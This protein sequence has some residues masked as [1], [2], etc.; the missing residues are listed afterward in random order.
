M[1]HEH[2]QIVDDVIG[3]LSEAINVNLVALRQS[4]RS[5]VAH[6]VADR[7]RER[8]DTVVTVCGVPELSERPLVALA[9]AGVEVPAGAAAASIAAA[10]AA[11]STQLA[12]AR[13]VLVVDD[14]DDLDSA[15]AGAIV[16]ARARRAFPV[17]TVTRPSGLRR[18]TGR[19]LT[20]GIQPSVTVRLEP[21]DF[22]RLHQMVHR[23]LA[24]AIE[25]STTAR[26]ATVSGGLPGLVVAIVETARRSGLLVESDGIWR[27]DGDLWNDQLVQ[28]VDP[29]LVDL[30]DD[31]LDALTKLSFAGTLTVAQAREIVP[32]QL[33]AQ[34]DGL[35]LLQVAE[36]STGPL[37]GVFPPLVAEY[38]RHAAALSHLEPVSETCTLTTLQ[39]PRLTLTSS[40]AVI[41][42]T[43]INEHWHAE[44]STRRAAWNEDPNVE[45]AVALMSALNEASAGPEVFAAVIDGTRTDDADPRWAVRFAEWHG[46][47][48][49]LVLGDL[50]GASAL[51]ARH[52]ASSPAFASQL[53]VAEAFFELLVGSV[54]DLQLPA[55]DEDPRGAQG[56][57]T[58]QI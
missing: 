3:Y 14:A 11:L 30:T 12:S 52:R 13:S 1:H 2:G 55:S 21:L 38:L 33:L 44:V 57:E 10:V 50:D 15:S 27:P 45:N 43:R 40:S 4:G 32:A 8:G 17:L 48:Q 20:A 34:L 37:T 31:E 49:A 6:L 35:G 19:T 58:V 18:T 47:Y 23:M 53:R 29:L 24:G 54:P 22:D 42:N 46:A 25:S 39:T 16:A 41:L 28:A 51:L 26:I 7:L 56:L 36:T 5:Q 9:L